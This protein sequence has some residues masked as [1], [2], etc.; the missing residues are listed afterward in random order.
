MLQAFLDTASQPVILGVD[1]N[2]VASSYVYKMVKGKK[3]DA[4]LETG[5]GMGKSY[6]SRLPNLRIDYIFMD[7]VFSIQQMK[8]DYLRLSDHLLLLADIS[9]K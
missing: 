1:M 5:F 6:Y 4:F 7:E 8:M 9:W 2:S 3:K